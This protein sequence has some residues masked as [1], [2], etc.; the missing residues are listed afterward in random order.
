MR[1]STKNIA[2]LRNSLKNCISD[3]ESDIA[4]DI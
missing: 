4:N 1:F 2:V 3:D